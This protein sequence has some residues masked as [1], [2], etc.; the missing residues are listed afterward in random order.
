[1]AFAPQLRL[2]IIEPPLRLPRMRYAA[3]WHDRMHRDPAHQWLRRTMHDAAGQL[4][5]VD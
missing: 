4:K 5:P 2:Q 1:M 3:Y